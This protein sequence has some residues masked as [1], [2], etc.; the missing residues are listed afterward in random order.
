MKGGKFMRF[1]KGTFLYD[2]TTLPKRMTKG[3]LYK[4]A[5]SQD[6]VIIRILVLSYT[7]PILVAAY[8]VVLPFVGI[9]H[10]IGA[11]FNGFSEAVQDKI[12]RITMLLGQLVVPFFA[13]ILVVKLLVKF[14]VGLSWVLEKVITAFFN[15]LGEHLVLSVIGMLVLI[16]ILMF[17][18]LFGDKIRSKRK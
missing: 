4:H 8:L 12:I 14:I 6:N 10:I 15:S 1:E 9:S 17:D 5:I 11:V 16:A 2:A 18:L 3:K 7:I 13:T